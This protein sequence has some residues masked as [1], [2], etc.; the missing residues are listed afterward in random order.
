SGTFLAP[1]PVQPMAYSL[2]VD[3][4]GNPLQFNDY[5]TAGVYP[6]ANTGFNGMEYNT[7][8]G[9]HCMA[10]EFNTIGGGPG[11]PLN[12]AQSFWLVAADPMG[13]SLC[14]L[15][16]GPMPVGLAP[17]VPN[18][19]WNMV[20][21]PVQVF[22]PLTWYNPVPQMTTQCSTCKQP[23]QSATIDGKGEV[24]IGYAADRSL[25]IIEI[26]GEASAQGTIE[27]TDLQGRVLQKVEA[28]IGKQY[29]DASTLSR[30]IYM[31]RYEIPGIKEGVKKLSIH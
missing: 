19:N 21:L 14:N 8:T 10:G 22:S 30:G 24:N 9:T 12:P 17:A 28:K 29:L 18:L 20:P 16:N 26:V 27:L 2:S 4:I 11:W 23:H 1:G 15:V 7:Y 3:M 6:T 25:I 5:E 31:L 13:N